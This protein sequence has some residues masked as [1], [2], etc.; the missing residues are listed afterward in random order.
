MLHLIKKLL[1]A[2]GITEETDKSNPSLRKE[3]PEQQNQERD[4]ELE[5]ILIEVAKEFEDETKFKGTAKEVA[6]K[7]EFARAKEL[8]RY[9]HKNP[10]EPESLKSKTA[11]YG[12]FGVWMNICQDSIFEILYH[13]KEEA[14]PTLYSIGFGEYDWTQY[15]AIDVL[16]RLANDGIHTDEIVKNIGNKIN[17]FRYEAV[18]PSI[19]SLSQISNNPEIPKIILHIFEEYSNDDPIDGLDILRVLVTNY[20][21]S[22]KSKLEFI[23]SIANGK[24]IENRSPLL[25]GAVL[26]IDEEGNESYSIEGEEVQ[27]NFEETHRINATALFYYLNSND[28]EMNKLME[29]WAENAKED[30]HRNMI[31]E[32]QKK[33]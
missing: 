25:D 10:P 8:P 24:G 33:K 11:K 23:K 21:E 16:C 29:Y 31:I 22:V 19:E 20:P 30:A 9:F 18:F 32:L 12:F 6:S 2:F 5:N 13:Y 3:I 15:K 4:L 28:K 1:Q 14:I 17:D 26:S 7:I 27:G